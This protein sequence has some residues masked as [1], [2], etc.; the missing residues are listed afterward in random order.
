MNNL[1]EITENMT[2]EELAEFA[3]E[4]NESHRED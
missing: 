1:K 3:E 2:E 4:W